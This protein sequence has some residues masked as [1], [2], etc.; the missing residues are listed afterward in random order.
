MQ[1]QQKLPGVP[2]ARCGPLTDDALE[3]LIPH[4]AEIAEGHAKLDDTT[5]VV[6]LMS[7]APMADELL[8]RR[9][10]MAVIQ[11]CSDPDKVVCFPGGSDGGAA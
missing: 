9:R 11:D 10:L 6:L 3:D 7:W 1:A 2:L 8:R 5:A 4:I